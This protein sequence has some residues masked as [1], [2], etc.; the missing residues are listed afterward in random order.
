M[1]ASPNKYSGDTDMSKDMAGLKSLGKLRRSCLGI[2]H[3]EAMQSFTLSEFLN[4]KEI[5]LRRTVIMMMSLN[6]SGVLLVS[7][8]P[9]CKNAGKEQPESQLET[10]QSDLSGA[11]AILGK[12]IVELERSLN[13]TERTRSLFELVIAQPELDMPE[14]LWNEYIDFE[15]AEATAFKEVQQEVLQEQRQLC[16]LRVK[17]V[18]ENAIDYYK[19][20]AP[21]LK[22]EGDMLQKVLVSF[23]LVELG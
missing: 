12:A 19:T 18:F 2:F 6:S 1:R 14:L 9:Y 17:R 8:S 3:G 22:E 11:R 13:E 16:I 4:L 10:R 15:I 5:S 7:P 20:S 21:E 23:S